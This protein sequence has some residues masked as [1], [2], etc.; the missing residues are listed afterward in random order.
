[1]LASTVYDVEGDFSAGTKF[2][3]S[4]PSIASGGGLFGYMTSCTLHGA[5]LRGTVNIVTSSF[6]MGGIVGNV[7]T[8][9]VSQCRNIATFPNGI[10][11]NYVGG[12]IGHTVT[13]IAVSDCLN[14]MNGDMTSSNE[15]GGIIGRCY[16]A[17][18]LDN[19]VNS[20][21]GNI[22]GLKSG[23]IAGFAWSLETRWFS[24]S[25]MLNYM[26][27]DILATEAGGIVGRIYST[28]SS[29]DCV[30]TKSIVAMHGNVEGAVRGSE[31]FTHSQPEVTVDTTFGMHF[32]NNDYGQA[33]MVVDDA[34]VYHPGFTDL[35]Y[36]V[37]EGTDPIGTTYDWDF[38]YANLG[39]KYEQYTHL[40]VHTSPSISAP[41]PT[42]VGSVT[43]NTTYLAFTHIDEKAIYLDPSLSVIETEAT[44]VFDLAKTNVVYGTPTPAETVSWTK[45]A[46]GKF[47]IRTKQHLLQLMQKGALYTDLGARPTNALSYWTH[48]YVQTA[49]IDFAGDDL[50]NVVHIGDEATTFLGSYEENGFDV[51]NWR[52]PGVGD[53]ESLFGTYTTLEW[54]TNAEGQYEVASADH[55]VQIMQRGLLFHDEGDFPADHWSAS[56]IQTTDI[57]LAECHAKI[58]PIGNATTSFT[59]QYDGGHFKLSNWS[60]TQPTDSASTT[61]NGLFGSVENAEVKRVCLTGVWTLMGS[62]H[63]GLYLGDGFLVGS[64][65]GST[66]YDIS[67]D[68]SEGTTMAGGPTTNAV[69]SHRVGCVIGLIS[70]SVVCGVTLK[71]VVEMRNFVADGHNTHV[72]GVV[73]YAINIASSI[74]FC[75]NLAVFPNNLTGFGSAGGIVGYFHMGTVEYCVNAMQGNV[76]GG[77]NAGGVVGIH[78]TGGSGDALVNAMTGNVHATNNAG[79]IVGCVDAYGTR[80][81]VHTRLM[82]YMGGDVTGDVNAGGVV[83]LTTR[84]GEASTGDISITNSIVAMHGSVGQ[85]V[86]GS[87]AFAPSA[88][89]VI[90]NLNFGMVCAGAV[91]SSSSSSLQDFTTDPTFTDLPY[92]EMSGTD[93][94]GFVQTFDFVFANLGGHEVYEDVYTHLSLH[95]A[96]VSTPIPT[97]YGLLSSNTTVYR[98]YSHLASKAI[99]VDDALTIVETEAEVAYNHN[100]SAVLLGLQTTLPVICEARALTI[101]ATL[102]LSLNSSLGTGLGLGDGVGLNAHLTHQATSANAR[103]MVTDIASSTTTTAIIKGLEPSTL[104]MIRLYVDNALVEKVLVTTSANSA[105]NYTAT[106]FYSTEEESFDISEVGDKM[107]AAIVNEVFTTGD[108]IEVD[109]AFARRTTRETTFVKKGEQVEMRRLEALLLPFD[110][111][112]TETQESSLKLSDDT[113]VT[114]SL[115][116]GSSNISIG[117]KTYPSGRSFVIDGRKCTVFDI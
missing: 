75:R 41:L 28:D 82:N 86:A 89:D 78:V 30:I 69:V 91:A 47:E 96:E 53:D 24:G 14:G 35:P 103:E 107:P 60:Y 77:S 72:G 68:L 114:V 7:T 19:V 57:D 105:E 92:V 8:G 66:V 90:V 64:A 50:G 22:S 39:G 48:H 4:L 9:T 12:I 87:S 34:L 80:T 112:T 63:A 116:Q 81:L 20:M 97:D 98:T 40:S 29:V 62:D 74:S 5:T 44:V 94:D 111:S 6:Y 42:T 31:T 73:G 85:A 27:G 95:T 45:D 79:G 26:K 32:D 113:S 59:G 76:S 101:K 10:S 83:G 46:D 58:L 88:L 2:T 23:G 21:T 52:G 54:T 43:A 65:A 71:G 51:L 109:M 25:K 67:L 93:P 11:G 37:L 61:A 84:T 38:V 17:A 33:T 16:S 104:Y 56:Y 70:Q 117:G 115:S 36:F 55:L 15:S 13:S 102:A 108:T 49:E 110:P 3:G 100:K 106:D 99:Y 1:M 18:T